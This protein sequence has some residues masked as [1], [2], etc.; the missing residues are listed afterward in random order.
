MLLDEAVLRRPVGGQETMADQMAFLATAAHRTHVALQI[1]PL[2]AGAHE[3][4]RGGPFVLADF[5]KS[6]SLGYQDT[7]LTGQIVED[8]N[9]VEALAVT[10]DT[11][12]LEALPRGASLDLVEEVARTWRRQNL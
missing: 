9:Q 1:I 3:G 7:A 4:L 2:S 5:S 8:A 11:L 10:W 12:R 6:P